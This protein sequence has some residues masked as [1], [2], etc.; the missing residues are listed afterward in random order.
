M[1]RYPQSPR[2]DAVW[3]VENMMGPCSVWLIEALTHVMPLLRRERVMDLGCGKAM[4]SIF[5]AR[6][7]GAKVEAID[8]WIRAEEKAAPNCRRRTERRRH[9]SAR[10]RDMPRFPDA[11]FDANDIAH[12]TLRKTEAC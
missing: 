4:S 2:Y 12:C 8:L 5:L 9:R 10:R 7:F 11:C 1:S 6:E 3:L